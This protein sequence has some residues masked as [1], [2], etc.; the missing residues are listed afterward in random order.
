MTTDTRKL[1]GFEHWARP[2]IQLLR[3]YGFQ[4]SGALNNC[5]GVDIP[6]AADVEYTA[7]VLNAALRGLD[8]TIE[9]VYNV[10]RE[11]KKANI[12]MYSANVEK[13]NRLLA[14]MGC[15]GYE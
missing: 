14:S 7:G 2:L 12:F 9:I 4:I 10:R 1:S 5:V 3:M 15:N 8:V 13:N 6:F 11:Y